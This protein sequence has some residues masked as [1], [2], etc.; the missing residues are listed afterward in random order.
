MPCNV[1]LQ[2]QMPRH[3]WLRLTWIQFLIF[4]FFL[5]LAVTFK[6]TPPIA[7]AGL[8]ELLPRFVSAYWYPVSE[9]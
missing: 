7:I 1:V 3:C 9:Q 5:I 8:M 2:A 4:K 6:F